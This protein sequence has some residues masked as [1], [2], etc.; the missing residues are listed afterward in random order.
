MTI[1]TR[2]ASAVALALVTTSVA[3]PAAR[4]GDVSIIP[5][6]VEVRVP[7]GE[8]FTTLVEIVY[9]KSNDQDDM[10]LRIVLSTEDWDMNAEGRLS[11]AVPD[12]LP[13]SAASWVVFSPSEAEIVPGQIMHA[14]MSVIVPEDAR[15][16]EY[17]AALIAQ[18]RP[19]YRP[20]EE[21]QKRL[22]FRYRLASTIYVSVPPIEH[23]LD[24]VGLDV[25]ADRGRWA[26]VP[27]LRNDGGEHA[28]IVDSF[29]VLPIENPLLGSAY[30][31]QTEEAGV[32]LPGRLRRLR[33]WLPEYLEPGAY[34]IVYEADAGD[35]YPLMVG[36]STFEIPGPDDVPTVVATRD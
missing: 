17:R 14:R 5:S 12:S 1:P 19:A 10:P 11:Y 6:L 7:P 27:S 15:G 22:Q 35:P 18:P 36:E 32:V 23:E 33:H 20:L 8:D 21:N 3:V 29:E 34:R 31:K 2:F 28:R 4:A 26:V 24:L 13:E 9:A 25:V 30:V 16:G